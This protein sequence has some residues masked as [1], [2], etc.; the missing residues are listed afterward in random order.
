VI[1]GSNPTY[2]MDVC[3]LCVLSGRGLYDDLITC[4]EESYRP[5]RAVVS[6]PENLMN[7]ETMAH[8]RGYRTKNQNEHTRTTRTLAS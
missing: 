7:K 5:W 4:P 2:G 1:V 8:L 3:L 6:D